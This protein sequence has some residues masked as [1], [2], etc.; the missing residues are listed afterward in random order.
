M[1]AAGNF[2]L[3][4]NA[5]PAKT[6]ARLSQIGQVGGKKQKTKNKRITGNPCEGCDC[7]K[8][9][10]TAGTFHLKFNSWHSKTFARLGKAA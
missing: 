2:H 9:L 7:G 4:C 3:K 8:G 10:V 6:F 5:G 1:V